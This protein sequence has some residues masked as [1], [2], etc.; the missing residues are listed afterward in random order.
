MWNVYESR[1]AQKSIDRL[2]KHIIQRYEFWKNIVS[3]SGPEALKQISGFRDHALKGNWEGYRS[4]S[5]NAQYR[6]L[7]HIDRK[8]IIVEVFDMN[9]H[10]Y[11]I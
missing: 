11:K 4:S 8:E 7:Y 1:R 10:N 6:V 9:A 3:L 2:S 5:L